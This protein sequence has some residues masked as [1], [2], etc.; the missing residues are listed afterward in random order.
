MTNPWQTRLRGAIFCLASFVLCMAFA[1][2][3]SASRGSA[4]L[5]LHSGQLAQETFEKLQNVRLAKVA[6]KNAP[7]SEAIQTI[8][9][10]PGLADCEII[11][12]ATGDVRVTVSPP[13]TD[14]SLEQ[15]LRAIKSGANGSVHFQVTHTG[16]I[17]FR[18][19]PPEIRTR[20]YFIRV[21]EFEKELK[22]KG[23]SVETTYH[24]VAFSRFRNV[25]N[26]EDVTGVWSVKPSLQDYFAKHS[27]LVT[28][29]NLR[30]F[31]H[32]Q[33]F[34]VSGDPA[35]LKVVEEFL[36]RFIIP[37][38]S[39]EGLAIELVEES[40]ILL[41]EGK[42]DEAQAT[43]KKAIDLHPANTNAQHWM[44]LAQG[45]KRVLTSLP[46][47]KLKP[48]T[49]KPGEL[50]TR[51]YVTDP[52]ISVEAL[53]KWAEVHTGTVLPERKS[54]HS[55]NSHLRAYFEEAGLELAPPKSVFFNT[56]TGSVLIRATQ[57]D[58]D[59]IEPAIQKLMAAP[60]R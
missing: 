56:R 60:G 39:V 59:M 33:I 2:D 43:L 50:F 23:F 15:A 52:K 10:F 44:T 46:E 48:G 30:V 5:G 19:C 34:S 38:G 22:A 42:F 26:D 36:E 45:R 21:A 57:R 32:K 11:S 13:L 14:V 53:L 7:L 20:S 29:G 37:E 58:L 8:A 3:A 16:R 54:I 51:S 9:K 41:A 40:K 35:T 31:P 27:I 6:F 49:V 25:L 17:Q 4:K 18:D 55:L 1:G 12:L 47:P 28:D 24:P